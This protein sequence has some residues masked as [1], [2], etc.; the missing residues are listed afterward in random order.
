[1]HTR[2]NRLHVIALTGYSGRG[3]VIQFSFLRVCVCVRAYVCVVLLVF[4]QPQLRAKTSRS[5]PQQRLAR[6]KKNVK[7]ILVRNNSLNKQAAQ[8]ENRILPVRLFV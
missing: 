8:R 2:A 1:M 6:N 3:L 7:G 4:L 5:K